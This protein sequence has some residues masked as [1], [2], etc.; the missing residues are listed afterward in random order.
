MVDQ[1]G[2]SWN[3]I[4][5]GRVGEEG[6]SERR[7]HML[8]AAHARALGPVCVTDNVAESKRVPTLKVVNWL[9]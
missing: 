6:H 7:S 1:N 5:S 3:Q 4:Y 8:I 2:G 9:R